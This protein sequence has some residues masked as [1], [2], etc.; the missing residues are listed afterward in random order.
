MMGRYGHWLGK[1]C[2]GD[3]KIVSHIA[4]TVRKQSSNSKWG[5][6]T[7]LQVPPTSSSGAPPPTASSTVPTLPTAGPDCSSTQAYCG[8]GI[9]RHCTFKL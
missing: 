6:A 2:A 4:A 7:K 3:R 1:A 8:M 5:E 9:G